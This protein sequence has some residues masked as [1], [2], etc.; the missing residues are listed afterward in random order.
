MAA[1]NPE[2][3]EHSDD[4]D[5]EDC[6]CDVQRT[7]KFGT[8]FA[9]AL[10][11]MEEEDITI[12]LKDLGK[13]TG[14]DCIRSSMQRPRQMSD[15]HELLGSARVIL[16]KCDP[17]WRHSDQE[18]FRAQWK[19]IPTVLLAVEDD[20]LD[21]KDMQPLERSFLDLYSSALTGFNNS[22]MG[23]TVFLVTPESKALPTMSRREKAVKERA[24]QRNMDAIRAIAEKASM[25]CSKHKRSMA[26]TYPLN[27]LLSLP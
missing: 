10:D 3:C 16:E 12:A 24:V 9:G 15:F 14:V 26:G 21:L 7:F 13:V 20:S 2:D 25:I 1:I 11:D 18:D 19:V 5:S 22:F 17:A 23:R 27:Y 4:S 8:C 6:D